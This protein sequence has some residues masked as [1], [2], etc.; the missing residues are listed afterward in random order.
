MIVCDKQS[1]DERTSLD[2]C[3]KLRDDLIILMASKNHLTQI[4]PDV[5]VV[6]NNDKDTACYSRTLLTIVS[7]EAAVMNVMSRGSAGLRPTGTG[8]GRR[9]ARL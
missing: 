3:I 7:P 1:R 5:P 6:L 4:A 9:P 8:C 2:S